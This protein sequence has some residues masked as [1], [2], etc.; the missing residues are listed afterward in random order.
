MSIPP[1]A[2]IPFPAS[3]ALGNHLLFRF[4][5]ALLRL[6]GISSYA[7]SG[8]CTSCGARCNRDRT[9][10]VLATGVSLARTIVVSVVSRRCVSSFCGARLGHT[11]GLSDRRGIFIWTSAWGILDGAA[12]RRCV[13]VRGR[14]GAWSDATWC[15]TEAASCY[16]AVL[17]AVSSAVALRFNLSTAAL[18]VVFIMVD[19]S[20]GLLVD[21]GG[22]AR[23]KRTVGCGV[24]IGVVLGEIAGA[25]NR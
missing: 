24:C 7:H 6:G 3:F 5:L 15:D 23:R 9:A 17:E 13:T 19:V 20:P 11:G 14:G 25:L 18:A 2:L 22:V 1:V 4:S 16:I 12:P 8:S 21:G 10:G